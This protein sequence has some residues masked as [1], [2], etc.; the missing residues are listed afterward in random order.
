MHMLALYKRDTLS[1]HRRVKAPFSVLA[2]RGHRFHFMQVQNFSGG[3]TFGADVTVLNNWMLG[4]EELQELA[5]VRHQRTIVC[6]C[7]D[8]ALLHHEA[9][10]AQMQLAHLVTVPNEYFAKE[11]R[12]ITS[13]VAVTPSCVDVDYLAVAN[14]QPMPPKVTIGCFGPFDWYLIKEAIIRVKEQHPHVIFL[15]GEHATKVLGEALVLSVDEIPTDYRMYLRACRFGILPLDGETPHDDIWKHEYGIMCRPTLSLHVAHA[16]ETDR[17]VAGIKRFLID[18]ERAN[19]GQ[20]AY[21]EANAYRPKRLAD[22]Y[23]AVYRK[24][25]PHLLML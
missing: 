24:K 5:S 12:I 8:P 25:L 11:A 7:S 14:R 2:E 10:R 15:G 1:I 13:H 17:W 19:A 9:Y 3:L 20:A 21:T 4:E 23:L 22:Q 16:T 6:D 18:T